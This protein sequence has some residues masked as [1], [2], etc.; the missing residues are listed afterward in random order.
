LFELC[1][2]FLP[3]ET[4]ILGPAECPIALIAGNYRMQILLR[5]GAMAS[6]HAA[7][8]RALSAYEQGRDATVYLEI[9]V[10]PVSML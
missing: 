7:A 3:P 8:G 2:S 1:R 6:L 5:G 4:G 10:D 9:D